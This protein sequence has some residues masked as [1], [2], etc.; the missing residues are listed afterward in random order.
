MEKVWFLRD[1]MMVE[2]RPDNRHFVRGKVGK[3]F[4]FF[5]RVCNRKA[6]RGINR[7]RTN[8]LAI[9]KRLENGSFYKHPLVN[10]DRR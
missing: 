4:V 7:G 10:Y 6:W 1:D 3:E 9:H 2:R 5:A 8:L